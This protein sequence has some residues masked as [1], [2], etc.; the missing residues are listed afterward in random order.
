MHELESACDARI[1]PAC[2]RVK[3]RIRPFGSKKIEKIREKITKLSV[4][5][6]ARKFIFFSFIFWLEPGERNF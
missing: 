3:V 4:S 6:V 5:K 2:Q 1:R